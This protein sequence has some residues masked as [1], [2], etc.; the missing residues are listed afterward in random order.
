[1]K[2]IIEQARKRLFPRPVGGHETQLSR[3]GK[4]RE[5]AQVVIGLDFGTAFT[6][7]V[8]GARRQSY[9]VPFKKY[10][11]TGKNPYLLP[12]RFSVMNDGSIR[13][14]T[15]P[16]GKTQEDLKMLILEQRG[17]EAFVLCA[18]FIALVLQEIRSWFF[19]AHRKD[20]QQYELDWYINVGLPTEHYH[21]VNLTAFYRDVVKASW[22]VST[23]EEALNMS[24]FAAPDQNGTH[25]LS[26][27]AIGLFPEFAAQIN[28]YVR[29]PMRRDDLHLLMDVGAGTL[30]VAM[31]NVH[32]ND[33][34]DVFPIFSKSVEK[35]GV[36]FLH[37]HR[38]DEAGVRANSRARKFREGLTAAQWAKE[39]GVTRQ[40]LS[41]IDG[42]F[43]SAVYDQVLN[44][45]RA[46]SKKYP[47]SPKWKDGV[48]FLLCGG[49][50]NVDLY[51]KLAETMV[52]NRQPT[53]LSRVML[54][55]PET[56]QAP[57]ADASSYDR[58]SV[59]YGLSFD[60]YNI[61]EVTRSDEIENISDTQDKQ[62]AVNIGAASACQSCGGTGGAM[63]NS[64]RKCGGTGWT[65]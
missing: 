7:V 55:K 46:A 9:A 64:C 43:R 14:G 12:G 58:L 42:K 19:N 37:A 21:N 10:V 48:S 61:G 62:S 59:A 11:E 17:E 32:Q 40:K 56:L 45:K 33:G 63:A 31:F 52:E 3:T 13:L 60:Q 38:A 22:A 39:L 16:G 4:P 6:K 29:S 26:D 65:T 24:L 28:G 50:A 18:A 20:Y 54:P 30:D 36:H 8:I 47:R 5:K 25:A 44:S 15:A 53:A 34:E 27:H 41:S 23:C 49:G 2:R 51:Q 57:L 1:M 35:Y